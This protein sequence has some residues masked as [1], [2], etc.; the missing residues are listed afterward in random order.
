MSYF[1]IIKLNAT[2]ST[3]DYFKEKRI[4]RNCNDGEL[5]WTKHQTSGRGQSNKAWEAQPNKSLS[6]SIYRAFDEKSPPHPFIISSAVACA[7]IRALH[8]IGVPELNI[9]WP[10]DIL[11]CSQKIGGILIENT[12]KYSRLNET[13]IGLGLNINQNKFNT[14]P[15]ASSLLMIT[16]R[17]W[18]IEAVLNA[19]I[20]RFESALFSDLLVAE[21]AT[22]AEFNSYLWRKNK[23]SKFESS[24]EAFEAIPLGVTQ[25]GKLRISSLDGGSQNTIDLK[26]A[27]MLYPKESV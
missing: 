9:K 20:Q 19:L 4:K 13:I 1:D 17:K 14:L 15:H 18:N 11:S 3:N 22:L 26:Q 12:Y 6:L 21:K 8:S 10:N 7:T 23:P 27:R 24:K 2:T 5:V 25:E 16:E